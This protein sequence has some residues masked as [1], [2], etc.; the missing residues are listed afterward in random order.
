ML[1]VVYV[2]ISQRGKILVIHVTSDGVLR[3]ALVLR[4]QNKISP[5]LKATILV[6]PCKV[7]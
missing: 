4:T 5:R 1:G 6:P 3:K 7:Y 2:S